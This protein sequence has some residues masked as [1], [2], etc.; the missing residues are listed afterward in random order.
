MA[1]R[2]TDSIGLPPVAAADLALALLWFILGF[3]LFS[4]LFAATAALVNK[5]SEVNTAI[6]PVTL[7]L[8]AGYLLAITV[9]GPDPNS[10]LSIA[11]SI[12]PFTAPLAM[13]I[14]W[15]SGDVPA[16][17]LALAI[18]LTV[19]TAVL[20]AALGSSMYRKALLITGRRVR[21]REVVGG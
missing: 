10:P 8:L 2:V 19:A 16:Y 3:A 18:V 4:F 15:A 20:L 21:L 1:V 7:L 13:P 17:Q 14:R 11:A 5:V 12:F 9:V 6:M